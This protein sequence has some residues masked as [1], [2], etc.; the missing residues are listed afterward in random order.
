MKKFFLTNLLAIIVGTGA[1]ACGGEWPA[2]HNWYMFSMYPHYGNTTPGAQQ[3]E[4]FWR[5]YSGDTNEY[6]YYNGERML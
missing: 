2:T 6:F 1:W 4:Q 5:N 3:I